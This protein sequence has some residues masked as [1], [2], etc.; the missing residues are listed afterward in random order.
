MSYIDDII[1]VRD[2]SRLRELTKGGQ[3]MRAALLNGAS[4][5]FA[6]IR[7]MWSDSSSQMDFLE[8]N[9]S[10][11]LRRLLISNNLWGMINKETTAL[12]IWSFASPLR[13]QRLRMEYQQ[14]HYW[15]VSIYCTPF[16]CTK[17]TAF[18]KGGLDQIWASSSE[19]QNGQFKKPAV[20]TFAVH[21]STWLSFWG[22]FF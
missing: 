3:L 17:S 14:Y 19:R 4:Y 15:Q 2:E 6:A 11:Q 20:D 18:Q 21:C 16:T 22:S 1:D 9:L 10:Q 7:G 13:F 5:I 12:L 8:R